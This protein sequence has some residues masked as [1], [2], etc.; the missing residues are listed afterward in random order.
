[1]FTKTASINAKHNNIHTQKYSC[2]QSHVCWY[3]KK[4]LIEGVGGNKTLEDLSCQIP[5]HSLQIFLPYYKHVNN[6][7]I[8][9]MQATKF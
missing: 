3:C 5:E 7:I 6:I 2:A 1:M 8:Y 4:D 9:K